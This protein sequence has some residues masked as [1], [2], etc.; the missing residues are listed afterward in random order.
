MQCPYCQR[1]IADNSFVC[2]HCQKELRRDAAPP[3]L[4][5]VQP[6]PL[7]NQQPL[8]NQ[9]VF[10]PNPTSFKD[11]DCLSGGE[12]GMVWAGMIIIPCLA[13][14]VV[15]II[16]YCIKPYKPNK[17]AMLNKTSW[18]AFLVAICIHIFGAVMGIVNEDKPPVTLSPPP[19]QTTLQASNIS[20]EQYVQQLRD[21]NAS[22]D[23][24]ITSDN[25]SHRVYI[26]Q[27]TGNMASELDT[28]AI[29]REIVESFT[30]N[31]DNR[32]E[33][34]TIKAVNAVLEYRYVTSD[35][36]TVDVSIFPTEW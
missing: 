27:K 4:Q 9:G 18:I 2:I 28:T 33:I 24:Q 30:S 7:Q 15:S 25:N 31:P 23:V 34:E 8:H 35:G 26:T 11:N 1:E 32:Q 21:A 36:V 6:P 19:P 3:T 14:I 20:F 16:Y 13:A 5:V 12:K 17:A 22:P 29:K 10:V